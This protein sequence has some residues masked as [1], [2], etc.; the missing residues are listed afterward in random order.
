MDLLD[1]ARGGA[2][3]GED[4]VTVGAAHRLARQATVAHELVEL[5]AVHVSACLLLSTRESPRGF[6]VR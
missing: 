1:A 4:E 5:G 6:V 2:G 3:L